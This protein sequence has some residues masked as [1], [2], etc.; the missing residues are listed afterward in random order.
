M[1]DKKK[2][3]KESIIQFTYLCL[4]HN[5]FCLKGIAERKICCIGPL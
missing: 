5:G 2:F 4:I 1:K 3:S